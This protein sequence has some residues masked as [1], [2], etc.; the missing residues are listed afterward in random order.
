MGC[1]AVKVYKGDV[2]GLLM[3]RLYHFFH[4]FHFLP[5][6]KVEMQNTTYSYFPSVRGLPE[7]S[8]I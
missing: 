1:R 6:G 5:A 8:H 3:I 2:P 4:F 7:S